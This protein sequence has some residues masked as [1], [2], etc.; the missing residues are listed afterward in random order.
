MNTR[1]SGFLRLDER[2]PNLRRRIPAS[3]DD[4]W[5][6]TLFVFVIAE[7]VSDIQPQV[8]DAHA[9]IIGCFQGIEGVSRFEAEIFIFKDALADRTAVEISKLLPQSVEAEAAYEDLSV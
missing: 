5:D 1:P 8:H 3:D 4:L 9:L 2:F 7:P 6:G